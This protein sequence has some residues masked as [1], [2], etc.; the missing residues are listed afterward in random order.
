MLTPQENPDGYAKSAIHDYANINGT[1]YLLV[2]GT[3]DGDFLFS[4]FSFLRS[5]RQTLTLSCVV[6]PPSDNVHVQHTLVLINNLTQ[7]N[8]DFD[9][10]IYTDSDHAINTG[11]NTQR[12]LYRRFTEFLMTKQERLA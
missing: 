10:H 7:A 6:L 5:R 3:A 1:D 11:A 12:D 4:F 9:I 8:V 2:H